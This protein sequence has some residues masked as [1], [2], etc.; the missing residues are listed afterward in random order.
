L[1]KL[2]K[3]SN[4][5]RIGSPAPFP[6][7]IKREKT[8]IFRVMSAEAR[9]TDAA[10]Q[11]LPKP[12]NSTK[13][14]K[15]VMSANRKEPMFPPLVDTKNEKKDD[16]PLLIQITQIESTPATKSDVV[17]VSKPN[18]PIVPTENTDNKDKKG[19]VNSPLPHS[20]VPTT[21]AEDNQNCSQP[22]IISKPHF[23][24]WGRLHCKSIAKW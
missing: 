24:G 22:K 14:T 20:P 15:R 8:A 10:G 3:S 18:E 11:P 7:L 2:R 21:K 12:S 19:V 9:E 6:G 13:I 4:D 1:L 16:K 5:G 23:T 17:S